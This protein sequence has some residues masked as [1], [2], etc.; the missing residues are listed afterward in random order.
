MVHR[1]SIQEAE[2][3]MPLLQAIALEI[4][5]RRLSIS[6]L[7]K[8]KNDLSLKASRISPEGF[9]SSLA[10][11]DKKLEIHQRG[12]DNAIAELRAL[13]LSLHSIQPIIIHI[14]GLHQGEKVVFCWEERFHVLE[15]PQLSDTMQALDSVE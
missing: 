1:R 11:I 7:R 14:P 9:Q 12:L 15:D 2:T 10:E 3:L 13:G 4:K 5:D 6:K 8:L